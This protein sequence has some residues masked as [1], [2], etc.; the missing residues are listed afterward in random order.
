MFGKI[1]FFYFSVR[2]ITA[3]CRTGIC[4]QCAD[5]WQVDLLQ[6]VVSHAA[7]RRARGL[8]G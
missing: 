8:C 6:S 1:N 4:W 3:R 2:T 5:R 7:V